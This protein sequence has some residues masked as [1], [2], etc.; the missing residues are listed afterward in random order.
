MDLKW[1]RLR[2]ALVLAVQDIP[3]KAKKRNIGY[4]RDTLLQVIFLMD[5]LEKMEKPKLKAKFARSKIERG[6]ENDACATYRVT[7]QKEPCEED[8]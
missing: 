7:I 6:I 1:L 2:N 8:I 4:D 3:H 5:S